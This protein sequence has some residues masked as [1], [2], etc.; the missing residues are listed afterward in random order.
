LIWCGAGSDARCRGVC[1]KRLK[2]VRGER[3]AL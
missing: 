1:V 2:K 3:W